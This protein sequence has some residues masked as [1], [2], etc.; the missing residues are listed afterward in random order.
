[1][2]AQS[3][4]PDNASLVFTIDRGGADCYNAAG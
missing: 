4:T 1:M 3:G 2:L